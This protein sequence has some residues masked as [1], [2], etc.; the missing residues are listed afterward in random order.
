ML[1]KK[2]KVLQI[3]PSDL[4]TRN[5]LMCGGTQR[6]VS[7]LDSSYVQRGIESYVIATA[8]SE[9]RGKLLSTI[10]QPLW[11][12]EREVTQADKN[13]IGGEHYSK[14]LE[15]ILD[16]N[17]DVIHDQA[18]FVCSEV[19][20]KGRDR[21]KCPIVVSIHSNFVNESEIEHLKNDKNIWVV[22]ISED[23]R[24]TL[25]SRGL[26]VRGRVYHGLDL[27][28]YPFEVDKKDFMF[29]IGRI[30]PDKGQD[31]AI[32]VARKTGKGLVIAGKTLPYNETNNGWCDENVFGKVD[33]SY[34]IRDLSMIQEV[35]DNLGKDIIWVNGLRDNQKKEF[36]KYASCL[37]APSKSESFGLTVIEAL[38]TGTPAIVLNNTSLPEIIIDGENGYLT[39]NEDEMV[40]AVGRLGS[41]SPLRCRQTVGERFNLE[42]QVNGYL[43]IYEN[44]INQY[45][46]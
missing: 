13:R 42:R 9:V 32:R 26:N 5:D 31:M 38:A 39:N 14:A 4:P 28:E 10:D 17:P 29:S 33:R 21:I 41:I 15:H 8:D 45:R 36:Y 24:R 23:H 40:E 30:V 7:S 3:S 1:E 11:E 44:A 2:L 43:R 25:E 27:S 12:Y 22:A 18:R 35:L 19:Y 20:K 46:N 6:V 37:I 34:E 16:I